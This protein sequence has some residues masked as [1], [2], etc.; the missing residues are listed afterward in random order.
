MSIIGKHIIPFLRK[1]KDGYAS[2][3]N[4][5]NQLSSFRVIP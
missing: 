2:V 5:E 4:G 1:Q 3:Y